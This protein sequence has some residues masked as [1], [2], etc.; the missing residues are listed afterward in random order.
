MD[1][2]TLAYAKLNLEFD[3][4]LFVNEYDLHIF[5]HSRPIANGQASIDGTIKLNKIWGMIDPNIY[6]LCDT[7]T[8]S[9]DFRTL[10]YIKRNY[11]AWQMFQLM[12]LDTK[13][14]SDPYLLHNASFGGAGLRNES[15]DKT[16]YIKA[17]FEQLEITKWIFKN[18]P[19]KKINS[20]H[21][22]SIEPTGFSTIHRDAKR[23]YDN[24][25][26]AGINK[27]YKNGFVIINLN[28]S[29]GGAPL[30]WALDGK[31]V[32]NYKTTDEQ[33]YL[34]NDYF[35]HGVPV[36]SFRRRQIRVTG[37]PKDSLWDLIDKKTVV[38]IGQDYQYDPSYPG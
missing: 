32:V 12:Q 29:S 7:Y 22:V 37:I 25:S 6:N 4:E 21:C 33:V 10:K 8:Q 35:F 19:F 30:Y 31:D 18:L 14:I 28:I 2:S 27:V 5:P 17:G 36:C 3:R 34:C 1:F 15:L 24:D 20:I 9:K 38:D 23:L 16:F 11:P 13:G 26:S